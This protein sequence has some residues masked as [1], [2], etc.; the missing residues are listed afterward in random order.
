ID[1]RIIPEIVEKNSGLVKTSP[2]SATFMSRFTD[3]LLTMAKI[4]T[5]R[6]AKTAIRTI[7]PMSALGDLS[8]L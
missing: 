6:A 8:S 4:M 1:A 7:L 2:N 3:W 5:P